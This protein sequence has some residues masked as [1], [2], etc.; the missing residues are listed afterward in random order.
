MK[1]EVAVG[2]GVGRRSSKK[3]RER[4]NLKISELVSN[5]S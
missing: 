1:I 5:G 2:K 4:E 3:K